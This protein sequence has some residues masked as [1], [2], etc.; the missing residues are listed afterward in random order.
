MPKFLAGLVLVAASLLGLPGVGHAQLGGSGGTGVGT[1]GTAG[2]TSTLT[3]DDFFIGVQ[4]VQ[5]TNLAEI[6]RSIYFNKANCDCEKPT[7]LF[8]ALSDSG[9]PKRNLI[10]GGNVQVWLGASCDQPTLRKDQCTLIADS[11]PLTDL[12]ATGGV[13]VA[14]N[15]KLL[16]TRKNADGTGQTTVCED[17]QKFAQTVW[18][19]VDVDNNGTF[20]VFKTTALAIDVTPPPP[21]IDITVR[22]GNEALVVGWKPVN[23]SVMEAADLLGFQLL[24]N[25]GGEFQVFPTG[26][27]SPGYASRATQCPDASSQ[28]GSVESLDPRFL[29]SGLLS[30]IST[31]NRIK[32]LQNA[33]TYGVTVL[34][35]DK[36]GNAS[37]ADV[38]Y[39]APVAS[40]DFY[41]IYRNGDESNGGP[42]GEPDPGADNGGFCAMGGATETGFAAVPI[43]GLTI[44][45]IALAR[46]RRRR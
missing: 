16:S 12:A 22:G 21:P 36:F 15:A 1:G 30:A 33:I 18:A 13:V 23:T 45:T 14:T 10:T 11:L 4:G 37:P 9:R 26:T 28:A 35:I 32:V 7:W 27:F 3:T 2:T 25:R 34:A 43:L 6:P 29:C 39:G 46:R 42:N 24:C 41:S 20:D 38:F 40:N 17:T 31:S 19:L 44:A 5:G 8:V